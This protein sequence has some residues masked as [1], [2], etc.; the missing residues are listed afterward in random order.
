MLLNYLKV[1]FRL[2]ARNRVFT[3]INLLGLST[4][5]A[6]F[7]LIRLFVINEKSYDRHL[8]EAEQIYRLGMKGDM[9]GFSFEAAVM[10]AP[11]GQ[12]V[13]EDV[14]EVL[15]STTF[16]KMPRPVL[17]SR[18]ENKF[19]EENIL[20]CDSL[21]IEFFGYQSILGHPEH[22][23]E[24]PYSMVLTRSGAKKYFGEE[25][26]VGKTITWNNDQDYTVTGVIEDP[27][28]NSHLNI[29]ILA[30]FNTLLDQDVYKNLLTTFYAFV[31][32]NYV[33]IEKSSSPSVIEE[34]I[35]G[36]VEKHMGEGM[37]E[38]GSHFEIF[39]QPVTEIHLNSKLVH[40][41]GPNGSRTSVMIFSA[42]SLLI[43]LIA[44]VNFIN[45]TTARS[46][47][48]TREIGIRKIFGADKEKL[49]GQF[50]LEALLFAMVCILL[51]GIFIGL[52]RN[53]IY[54]FSGINPEALGI[55]PALFFLFLLVLGLGI[56]F[57][58]GLYPSFFM[59]RSQALGMMKGA[60]RHRPSRPILRNI[61]VIIQL[62]ITLFL[63]FN[64]ILIYKQLRLVR[65]TDIGINKDDLLVIPMRSSEMYG[66][67]EVLQNEMMSLPG[68][69]DVT[70]TSSYLGSFEQR[71]GFQIEGYD[72]K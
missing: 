23:L 27:F 38:S 55:S 44:C 15:T 71:R 49:F 5:I 17:L 40:E 20:F 66:Q 48:R 37:K 10:G 11:F 16:Y 69:V 54:N 36:V 25:N 8:P 68:V 61:L 28:H 41:L 56:G 19:Y 3:I 51:A 2:F 70:A 60:V 52:L 9:S 32:Y 43:L 62:G 39:L 59:S 34:K 26:P 21:F 46:S 67:Y 64:T 65:Q 4:G 13:C 7:V 33:S 12:A 58:S 72:A 1:F 53:L 30:T 6:C 63:V 31:T 22:M 50:M 57:L 35:A 29:D 24:A 42:I 14:P 18:G 47:G 45:L